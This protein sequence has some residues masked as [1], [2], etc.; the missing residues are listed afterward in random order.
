VLRRHAAPAL[1]ELPSYGHALALLW[2]E[3]LEQGV[4]GASVPRS[5][6]G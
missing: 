4:C 1:P 6:R 5:G 2:R 3:G